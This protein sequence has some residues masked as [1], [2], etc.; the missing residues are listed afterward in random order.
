MDIGKFE[1]KFS[2]NFQD[3]ALLIQAFTHSSYANEYQGGTIE[4]NERLEF[5]GD[6]VLELGVSEYLFKK[7]DDMSEGELSKQRASI[8][9]EESLFQFSTFLNFN[10]FV[11]IGKSEERTGGRTRQSLLADVFEAFLG[12]LYI[13][14]GFE[15]CYKFLDK[16]VFPAITRD[17]YSHKM[18]YKTQLQEIIQKDKHA[19][20]FYK[21]I[22]EIG[23]SHN[24][25]FVIEVHV[26][27]LLVEKGT[28]RSK[29]EAEQLAA[30]KM[31]KK[32][33][34]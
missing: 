17:V 32:L 31:L 18:D 13:D 6:A 33:K 28:G 2:V 23:P 29:K 8:V 7:N 15:T 4:D 19:K 3:K 24:K 10:E 34:K 14:Q 27:D 21:V 26:N 16:N 22:D 30:K 20:L 12:A 1:Q 25:K 9:C 5:L 11:L